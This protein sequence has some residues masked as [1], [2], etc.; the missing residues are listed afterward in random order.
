MDWAAIEEIVY[1]EAQHPENL[2]GTTNVG[3]NTLVQCFFPDA[4]GVSLLTEDGENRLK[5]EGWTYDPKD[6]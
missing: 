5:A 6:N 2:L 1:G 4:A 3:R